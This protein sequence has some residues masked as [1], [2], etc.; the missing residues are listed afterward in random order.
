LFFEYF[1]AAAGYFII[2]DVSVNARALPEPA[3]MVLLGL[4]LVGLA[5]MRRFRK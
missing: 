2:D 1:F 3:T 5:G 4:G